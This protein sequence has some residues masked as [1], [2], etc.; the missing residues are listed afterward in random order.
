GG[1]GGAAGAGEA[2]RNWL[3]AGMHRDRLADRRPEGGWGSLVRQDRRPGAGGGD[4]LG[5]LELVAP[6]RHDADRHAGGK[7]LLGD[8]HPTVADDA[9]GGPQ[10]R[11]GWHPP[12]PPGGGRWVE[13]PGVMGGGGDDHADVVGGH[14]GQGGANQSIVVLAFAGRADQH[15]RLSQ[16]A[17]PRR[18]LGR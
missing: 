1:S 18:W 14:G 16:V 9:G 13:A 10:D 12:R 3:G 4:M 7:R 15:D 8:A 6:E 5:D 11:P 17:K 2:G